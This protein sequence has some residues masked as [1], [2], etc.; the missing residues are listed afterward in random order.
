MTNDNTSQGSIRVRAAQITVLPG[1]VADNRRAILDCIAAARAERVDLLVLPELCVSGYLVADEWERDSFLRDCEAVTGEIVAASGGITVVFGNVAVDRAKRNEDGRPRK[2]NALFT[3]RDGQLLA[4]EN[5]AEPFVIKALSPNYRQFD[6]SRHFFDLRKT[7]AERGA[8]PAS[9]IAPVNTGQVRLGCLLCED[10]WEDDYAFSP[11]D[12]LAARGIDFFVNISASPFT[13]G[14]ND[15]RQRVCQAISR[16]HRR[17]LVYVNQTGVQNNGKNIY[18]F[19]GGTCVYDGYGG[20]RPLEPAFAAGHLTCDIP[21]RR[22]SGFAPPPAG[23]G[24]RLAALAQALQYGIREFLRQLNVGRITIGVSGGIDSALVAALY[25]RCLEPGSL[26]LVNLPSI[27]NSPTTINLAR[28]LAGRLGALYAEVPISDSV[29]LTSRQLNGLVPRPP[30]VERS[31]APVAAAAGPLRL[32]GLMLE[33]IQARD[34]S[35][36][37]LAAAS[38]AFGGLFTCNANKSELTVGYGTLYG[39]L[40]GYLAPIGDLWKTEV[41]ELAG[42]LN[43]EVF[44][45]ELIPEG[46]IRLTPSAELSPAQNVDL[47]QG[48]PIL[49][50]YHDRLFASWVEWWNRAAPEDILAWRLSGELESRLGLDQPLEHWFAGHDAFVADLERWW[51]LY[52]GVAVAK[53]VQSPPILTVKRRA[54]GFDH[55]ECQMGPLYTAAYHR[56]KA[57]LLA[58]G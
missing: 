6:E 34:R 42:F 35:S 13:L 24:N 1:R 9:L 29:D 51:N 4:P 39:D 53:R 45:G 58:S 26:F 17:P 7:A 8:A 56:L 15:K 22:D 21:L 14:K 31:G 43:R 10:A 54:L 3:A 25:S 28:D 20:V 33:N 23:E 5:Q 36:R 12:Q 32:T 52:Q 55:R 44:A 40:C 16:R 57:Q 11:A 30:P 38:A 37:V 46:I 50:P 47:G 49:Y 19:D 2:Y 41:W 27:H 18:V 48:D